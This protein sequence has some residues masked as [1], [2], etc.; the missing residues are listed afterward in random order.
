MHVLFSFIISSLYVGISLGKTVAEYNG[1][2]D[3]TPSLL[4]GQ[5]PN[6][7]GVLAGSVKWSTGDF[8]TLA[9]GCEDIFKIVW[10][11]YKQPKE[12]RHQYT[13]KAALQ[14]P[15]DLDGFTP[16]TGSIVSL[17]ASPS[18]KIGVTKD[19]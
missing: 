11:N 6:Y 16:Y 3:T 2:P 10:G 15:F 5:V 9:A 8:E 7:I 19:A 12:C 17:F 14:G 13:T 18:D 1:N 4:D